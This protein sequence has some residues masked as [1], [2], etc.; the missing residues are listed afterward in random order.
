MAIVT[1]SIAGT[2]SPNPRHINVDYGDTVIF[3]ADGVDVVL[4]FDDITIFGGTRYEVP[5]STS[6]SLVVQTSA[7]PGPFSYV[8]KIGDLDANC[9][10]PRSGDEPGGGEVGGSS[11]GDG[12]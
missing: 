3:L 8:A 12:G 5:S 9:M 1:V 11:G 10:R 2:G 6:Q 7:T 4:C